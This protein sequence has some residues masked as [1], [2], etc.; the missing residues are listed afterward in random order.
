MPLIY[1][2]KQVLE[3]K[4]KRVE[5]AE[6]VVIERRLAVEREEEKLKQ[7]ESERDKVKDHHKAKLTQL[8]EE[9][10]RGTTS[11]KIQQ[12]KAYIK[13]VQENLKNEEKKVKEQKEQVEIAKQNLEI[14][15]KDLAFRRLEVDKIELHKKDWLKTLMKEMEIKEENE[16]NE[17][18]SV[19]YS[20]QQKEKKK[21]GKS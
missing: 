1:P 20:M 17:Q 3:V 15:I 8:R 7:R 16:F 19:I 10:D 11:D 13:V 6:K 9:L 2:L 14:A 5:D 21:Y 18:G 4:K 12:M